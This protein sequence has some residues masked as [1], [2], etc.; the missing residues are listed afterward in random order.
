MSVLKFEVG[1]APATPVLPLPGVPWVC[2]PSLARAS[3]TVSCEKHP[4]GGFFFADGGSSVSYT[5]LRAHETR[6]HL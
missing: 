4:T 3:S 6:R 2:I 5:H 1:A